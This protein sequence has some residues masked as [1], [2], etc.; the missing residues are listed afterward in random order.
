MIARLVLHRFVLMAEHEEIN[1]RIQCSLLLS[2]LVKSGVGDVVVIPSLDFVLEF[3]QSVLVRPAQGQSDANVRMDPTEKPLV[4]PTFK[5]LLQEFVAFV[6]G[7]SAIA[8]DQEEFFAFQRKDLG[9]AMQLD[10]Q[11]VM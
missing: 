10:A 1:G 9:L 11:L 7:T 6:A 2:V 3:L 4:N 8:V 5:N